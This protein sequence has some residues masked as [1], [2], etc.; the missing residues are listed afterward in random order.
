LV[1]ASHQELTELETDC[2]HVADFGGSPEAHL[3][4]RGPDRSEV[5]R[6]PLHGS[7]AVGRGEDSDVVL[8][9][10]RVSRA[11]A[12]FYWASGDL[13]LQD[14][15]SRNGTLHN[16]A[17]LSGSDPPRSLKAGDRV[18]VGSHEFLVALVTKV[19][20]P[21]RV[22]SDSHELAD[23]ESASVGTVVADPRL[24]R[25]YGFARRIAA[26]NATALILGETGTGKEVLA[27]QIHAWSKRK[28]GPLV[29]VNCAAL[30]EALVE[31]ELFGHEKGA[32]TGADRR[33]MGLAEAASGGTFFLD[34]IGELPLAVQ[35]KL[36]TMLE[37]RSIVRVGSVKEIPIDIRV[38]AATHRDLSEEVAAGRF[39]EDLFY[40]VR[41]AV[42]R[43]PPLRERLVE[44]PLLAELFARNLAETS[45]VEPRKSYVSPQ[46]QRALADHDWPGN[47]RELRNAI[48]HAMLVSENGYIEVEHLPETLGAAS[49]RPTNPP[50]NSVGREAQVSIKAK[51][52]DLERQAIEDMLR[53][54]GG[55]RTHAALE[56]G[57][58]LRS[59]LYKIKKYRITD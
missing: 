33:K 14:L 24:T 45:G 43:I 56:L 22:E 46:A 2:T 21:K 26:S 1:N 59:L 48:E 19:P 29:R 18:K 27:Q 31:S 12:K 37:N 6:L 13:L 47:I 35:A 7:V 39:R 36:L 42:L 57:I 28:D 34:E 5:V 16:G 54:K 52:A 41:V 40:R 8:Q 25:T 53:K 11:H 50:T 38:I 23:G 9:D 4:L 44:L 30:P 17:R 20:P 10:G 55:N 32:F 49:S 51:V 58:S 15:G 3:I